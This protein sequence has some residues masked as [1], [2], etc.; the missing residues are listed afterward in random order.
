MDKLKIDPSDIINTALAKAMQQGAKTYLAA[1]LF[2]YATLLTVAHRR[3]S[4]P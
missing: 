1:A 3:A 2:P 4:R